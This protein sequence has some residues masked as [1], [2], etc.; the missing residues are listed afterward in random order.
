MSLKQ[1]ILEY[2]IR[3]FSMLPPFFR[4]KLVH[5]FVLIGRSDW[6]NPYHDFLDNILEV[7]VYTCMYM[8]M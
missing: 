7:H 8:Y 6:P 5:L 1:F 3:N 2:L 4:N